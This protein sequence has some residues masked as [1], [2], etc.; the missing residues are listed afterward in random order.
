MIF[1]FDV[2]GVCGDL[3]SKLLLDLS[4][5]FD[6]LPKYEDIHDHG[7]LLDPHNSVLT[8]EQLKVAHNLMLSEGYSNTFDV[9]DGCKL[10]IDQLKNTGHTIKWVTAPYYRSK[11]WC[12]DRLLWL[13]THFAATDD[14][15]IFAQD[16]SLT[17]GDVFVDDKESNVEAWQ[18]RWRDGKAL[19]F[20]QPWNMKSD[21]PRGT[22]DEIRKLG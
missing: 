11:T 22:W 12:F 16:K 14:D 13:K 1:L 20:T 6:N 21:L 17:F 5:D 10:T 7:Q 19:L 3:V 9:I 2:D 15:V 18:H 8:K 4:K